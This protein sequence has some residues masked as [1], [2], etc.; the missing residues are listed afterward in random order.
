MTDEQ[1][2]PLIGGDDEPFW[3][4]SGPRK[5]LNIP[6]PVPDRWCA[7]LTFGRFPKYQTVE[8]WGPTEQDARESATDKAI[9]A[10][11]SQ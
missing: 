2:S 10:S 8:G 6:T 5:Y 7:K 1:H 4:I 9:A 11:V 3:E